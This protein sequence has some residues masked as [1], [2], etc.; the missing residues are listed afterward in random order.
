M[1]EQL[2]T[3]VEEVS[4]RSK[5]R[6]LLLIVIS[7]LVASILVLIS[8]AMYNGSGAAQLDLSRP[9]YNEVRDQVITDDSD[10]KNYSNT[11]PIDQSSISE[12]KLLFEKQS[13]KIEA[14]DAFGGDP[15]NPKALGIS[16]L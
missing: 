4:F 2:A 11:G 8:M 5:Y 16:A 3:K 13:Q 7:I 14:F 1:D 10:F 12:F 15:L 6:F 9:G